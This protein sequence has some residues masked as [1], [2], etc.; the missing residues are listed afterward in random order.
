MGAGGPDDRKAAGWLEH[1]DAA[2]SARGY[3]GPLP[4]ARRTG[5]AWSAWPADLEPGPR[6]GI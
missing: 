3:A 1:G 5:P 4:V 2:L 6:G